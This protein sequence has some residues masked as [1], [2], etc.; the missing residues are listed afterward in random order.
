MYVILWLK[1]VCLIKIRIN[2]RRGF[3]EMTGTFFV[4]ILV[5]V[6]K[7]WE[8][9]GNLGEILENFGMTGGK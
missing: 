9:G 6:G 2:F 7:F 5:K 3:S 4:L 8:F 1:S